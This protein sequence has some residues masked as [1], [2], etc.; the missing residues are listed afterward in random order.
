MFLREIISDQTIYSLGW[1]IVH[2]LWQILIIALALKLLLIIFKNT[3]THTRYTFSAAALLIILLA[4]IATFFSFYNNYLPDTNMSEAGE[5]TILGTLLARSEITEKFTIL[6]IPALIEEQYK[7][8]TTWI[9]TNMSLIVMLWMLGILIFMIKFS[10][11]LIYI[12]RLKRIGTTSVPV[13]WHDMLKRLSDKI[14]VKKH[15]EI[16]ESVFAKGPMIIGH[17]KPVILLPAGLLFSMP[18]NQIEAIFAHELA[19][20]RRRDYLVNTL[21]TILEVI[22]FYH[23][24]LWWISTIFDE[25]R[26]LCCD[27]IAL[28]ASIEPLSLSKALVYAEEYRMHSPGLALAFYKKHHSL[29]KRIKRM[30]TKKHKTQKFIGRPVA[31]AVIV[32]G[33][34][35]FVI[36]SSFTS[37]DGLVNPGSMIQEKTL[38][39]DDTTDGIIVDG[40]ITVTLPDPEGKYPVIITTEDGNTYSVY[41][42]NGPDGKEISEVWLDGKKVP[43]SKWKGNEDFFVSNQQQEKPNEKEMAQMKFDLQ[44]LHNETRQ[45]QEMLTVYKKEMAAYQEGFTQQEKE[46]IK[47]MHSS[48]DETKEVLDE[49]KSKLAE[50]KEALSD[51]QLV[52]VQKQLLEEQESLLRVNVKIRT[53]MGEDMSLT[54]AE[55]KEIKA[56]QA[57]MKERMK[58]WYP[59]LTNELTED[60]I[61][62]KGETGFVSLSMDEM[63]VNDVKQPAKVH[64]K[65][66]KLYE[67]MRGKPIGLMS[68]AFVVNSKKAK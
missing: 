22:F 12:Q 36:S 34:I 1:T 11:N 53:M 45:M 62:K 28:S 7:I 13:E 30:N 46:S 52:K 18:V 57:A 29:F 41:F 15:I 56:E 42:K 2:S 25:E 68:Y 20:V 49:L 17:L 35:A 48:L 32:T 37:S 31:L 5:P 51:D 38:T 55:L 60:G 54:K 6:T 65:Y 39:V 9:E 14:G 27:D 19:H 40:K 47:K 33:L 58:P 43:E 24:A 10:G 64:K 66:L 21:K 4:G 59:L 23:P 3:S 63:K 61:I 26:E 50:K 16:L 44:E 8:M 67:E